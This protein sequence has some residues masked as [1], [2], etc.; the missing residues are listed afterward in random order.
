MWTVA[1]SRCIFWDRRCLNGDTCL[2][3]FFVP[4]T[5]SASL[6][7]YAE[8]ARHLGLNPDAML[9]RVG[10]NPQHLS[11]PDMP[12]NTVSVRELLEASAA[13]SG[14]EDFGLQLARDRR[15]SNLGPISAVMREAPTAREALDVLCRY[16]RLLNAALLTRIEDHED[17]S[18]VREDV[19]TD[20]PGAVRQSIEMAVGVL[21]GMIAELVGSGW[22]P[23][24]VCFEH[25]PPH[26][27]TIH[28]AMFGVEVEFNASFNGIVCAARD[29]MAP[30]SATDSR[31]SPYARRFLDQALSTAGESSTYNARQI[32]TALLPSGR[33]TADQVAKHLVV[34]RR[35]LHR[36]LIAEGTTFSLLLR[37]V[38]S[39]FASRHILDS[40]RSLAELADL[41]GFSTPSAFAF[42]FRKN[43]GM[44]VS[45]WKQRRRPGDLELP[46]QHRFST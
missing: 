19:L 22:K 10:L 43:F 45:N 9:R 6:G 5:R 7:G 41:L 18:V 38:R 2:S 20:E 1:H 16:V 14:T 33:C 35:T 26:G 29:L 11:D 23:R 21:Y 34:D 3:R 12:I 40:D 39:E 36:H 28:R 32:I 13:A 15:L 24:R 25:R 37:T 46:G 30:L 17:L 31:L 8:L 27:P 4:M 44:T 42:W